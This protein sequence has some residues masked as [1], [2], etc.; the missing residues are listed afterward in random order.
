MSM[1][2]GRRL[3][4]LLLC[5]LSGSA[6]AVSPG[7]LPVYIEDS[8]A[9]SFYWMTQN[10]A[11]NRDYQLLLIDAHSDASEILGSDSIRDE[12]LH[13]VTEGRL[14]Q[15][16]AAWRV[17]G[18]VQC[19]NWIEP[20]IPSPIT[21]VWWVPVDTLTANQAAGKRLAVRRRI[22]AHEAAWPRRDGDFGD[23]YEVLGLDQLSKQ[24]FTAPLVVSL[25]LDFLASVKSTEARAQVER[26]LGII[27]KLP[28]LEALTI[29]ISRPYLDSEAQ[30]GL[31]LLEVLRNLTRI[32]NVEIRYEPFLDAGEDRSEMAK[33]LYR[34]KLQVP[35]YEIE[36]APAGTDSAEQCADYSLR[37]ARAL[38][39]T[40]RAVAR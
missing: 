17:R 40:D 21:K 37:G 16:A 32:V 9:G 11:L 36:A 28:R 19:Y 35:R 38:G 33:A 39:E 23:R 20:L 22:N 3:R 12:T 13:A 31:L 8:H 18:R 7:A 4:V 1:A 2:H 5:V 6:Q 25:D 27:L 24:T 15:L 30:A 14:E 34:R 10:L 29:A 26:V